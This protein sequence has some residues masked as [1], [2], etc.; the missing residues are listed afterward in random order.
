[1]KT[2][3]VLLANHKPGLEVCKILSSDQN[4]EIVAVF[5][6]GEIAQYDA[7]IKSLLLNDEIP[8]YRGREVWASPDIHKI[9]EPLKIDYLISVYWP[10]LIKEFVF[11]LFK[12]SI[13]FHPALLPKNRGWFPHVYNIKDGTQ[14]GVTLHRITIEADAGEIWASKEVELLPTDTASE[15]YFRLQSEIVSLF[16]RIWPRILGGEISAVPQK[17]EEATYNSKNEISTFDQINLDS[18]VQVRSFINLLRSRTFNGN[19]FAFYYEQGKKI[20]IAISLKE[21]PNDSI[22]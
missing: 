6:T 3:V 21:I 11:P 19:G 5:T 20:S 17:H 12:D 8:M 22:S 14:P 2:R 18:Q 9:L 10:W 15:L 13:N 7:E 1:M 4:V 16:E